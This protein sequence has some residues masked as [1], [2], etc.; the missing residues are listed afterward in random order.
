[1]AEAQLSLNLLV[2]F[3]QV[4]TLQWLISYVSLTGPLRDPDKYYSG[5]VCAGVSGLDCLSVFPLGHQSSVFGIEPRWELISLSL[6]VLR[7]LD[8][9]ENYTITGGSLASPASWLQVSDFSLHHSVSLSYVSYISMSVHTHLLLFLFLWRSPTNTF[10]EKVNLVAMS[11]EMVQMKF[12]FFKKKSHSLTLS[13]WALFKMRPRA[14]DPFP[15]TS[16]FS[17]QTA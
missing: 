5:C 3:S 12:W 7:A 14:D 6:L 4:S 10:Q 16:V 1:M 13:F 8:S 15:G 17:G 2:P 9:D 11:P